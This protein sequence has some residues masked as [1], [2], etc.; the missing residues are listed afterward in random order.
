MEITKEVIDTLIKRIE[1][2]QPANFVIETCDIEA[3][4]DAQTELKNLG[5]IGDVVGRDICG[6]GNPS[7]KHS[8]KN[9][10]GEIK[11]S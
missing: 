5:D 3:L 9:C 6:C 8:C 1:K 11:Y 7:V 4:K 2:A 10:G